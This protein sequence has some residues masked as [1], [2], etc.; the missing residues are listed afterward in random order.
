MLPGCIRLSPQQLDEF[1]RKGALVIRGFYDRESQ[2]VPVQRA[3]YDIIGLIAERHEMALERPD[4]TPD[5]FDAGYRQL[6]AIDRS[7]GGE[8]YDAIKQIPAFLRLISCDRNEDLFQQL[9][10]GCLPGTGA[11]SYGIRI[12]N[13]R[14]EEYR[15]HWHQEFLFQP[16]SIDGVVFWTSLVSLK[17]EMGPV[18]ICLGSHLDGLCQYTKSGNHSH[19]PGAYKIGIVDDESVAARYERISP[20]CEPGDLVVMDFLTI[21]QSGFNISD[22][23]RWSVQTRFFNFRDPIGMEIGWKPSVTAGSQ[24]EKIFSAN[25]VEDH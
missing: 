15:S 23:P 17:P 2:I 8:V 13:P 19:K 7:Y 20:L 5:Q 3:I 25:F 4:F 6:I 14:E 11:A 1:H 21:H 24:I 16:Q 12:D 18:Q 10:P 22:R 9:R